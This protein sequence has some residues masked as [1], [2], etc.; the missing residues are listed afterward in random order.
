[1]SFSVAAAAAVAADRVPR[2]T[3]QRGGGC[4]RTHAVGGALV[5]WP[6]R[7]A[8][9]VVDAYRFY[10]SVSGSPVGTPAVVVFD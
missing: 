9:G 1:V 2:T 3:R 10:Q 5:L 4:N 8:D 7:R 6:P